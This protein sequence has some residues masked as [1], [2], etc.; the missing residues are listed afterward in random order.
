MGTWSWLQERYE[1]K[2]AINKLVLIYNLLNMRYAR[3]EGMRDSVAVLQSQIT[4][5]ASRNTMLYDSTKFAIIIS[6]LKECN[7]SE[8]LNSSVGIMEKDNQSWRQLSSLFVEESIR[9]DN[10]LAN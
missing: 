9:L 7:E 3:E 5:L 8:Q 2:I 6:A 4:R 10:K 1:G